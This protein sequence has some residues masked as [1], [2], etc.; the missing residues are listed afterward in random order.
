[1]ILD[2]LKEL[3]NKLENKPEPMEFLESLIL[4]IEPFVNS[5]DQF[6]DPFGR[7]PLSDHE[8][9]FKISNKSLLSKHLAWLVLESFH[10]S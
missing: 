6:S 7:F 8:K 2:D 5:F 9:V 3:E 4:F 1:M 10:C